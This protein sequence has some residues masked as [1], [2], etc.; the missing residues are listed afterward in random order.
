MSH[1]RRTISSYWFE[2][3][4]FS[5]KDKHK[6]ESN[7][8]L[9]VKRALSQLMNLC[10]PPACSR[11][12]GP[13]NTGDF[14]FVSALYRMQICRKNWE[15]LK[16]LK[17]III[18]SSQKKKKKIL[19]STTTLTQNF[20]EMSVNQEYTLKDKIIFFFLRK[21]NIT[22]YLRSNPDPVSTF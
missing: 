22:W 14:T 19:T 12:S 1:I 15:Y 8:W 13:W 16:D 7:C 3:L 2:F 17:I 9:T 18:P 20:N 21:Q 4:S 5:F 10:S 6:E 11:S